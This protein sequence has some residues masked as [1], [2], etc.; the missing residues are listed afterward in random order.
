[1]SVPQ[2]AIV[3]RPNVGK[4]SLLNRLA[5]QRVSI[6]APTPG[7]TRDRVSALIEI[8]APHESPPGTPAKIAEVVDTGGYGAYTAGRSRYDDE[9]ADLAPL[10]TEIEAQIRTAVA[11]AALILLVVDVQSGVCALDIEIAAMLRRQGIGPEVIPVANKVDGEK[12]LA[13]GL[14]AASL[15]F[16]EPRCVSA[17]NGFGMREL[18]DELHGRV[19]AE[20]AAGPEPPQEM[21]L[22]IVGKRNAGKSTLINTLAG[23]PRVIVSEIPGTTRDAIDVQFEIEG[24][25]MLAIDTAG[26]RKRKSLTDDIEQYAYHRMLADIRRADVV[27]FLV[28]AAVEISQVDKKLSQELQHQFKPTVISVNKWD[29]VEEKLSPEDYREYLTRELRGLHY[30]PIA[31]TSA[32]E[33]DGVRD[34]VAMAFN[35]Y[36]QAG[37][38]ER[39]SQLNQTIQSILA[40]RGPTSKLGTEAKIFYVCQIAAHPPTIVLVVN[41]PKLFHG[42]YEQYLLNRLHEDLPCSEVP[43]RLLFRKRKRMPLAALKRLEGSKPIQ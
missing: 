31:F 14:E 13:H 42:G 27:V 21:K 29:L 2:I 11:Q 6:V 34:V 41:E 9:G 37:H 35:L 18:L 22:A 1:M 43:I 30:A 28:D 8:D 33:G 26:V 24:R 38:F 5:R 12:W 40:R 16:G 4:S 10:A 32:K 23:E 7:V 39:T 20:G 17:S 36:Q 25:T 3:G 19:A 15:G